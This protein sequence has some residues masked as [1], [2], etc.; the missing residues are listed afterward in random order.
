MSSLLAGNQG[1]LRRPSPLFRLCEVGHIRRF[2]A[3]QRLEDLRAGAL[4]GESGGTQSM[5]FLA[6]WFGRWRVDQQRRDW[7]ASVQ[8][9]MEDES[10][11]SR[12]QRLTTFHKQ[13]FPWLAIPGPG[14]PITVPI[15]ALLWQVQPAQ[16]HATLGILADAGLIQAQGEGYLLI[17]DFRILARHLL[18]DGFPAG[19]VF[20]SLNLSWSRA[21]AIFLQRLLSDSSPWSDH[22][23]STQL[24]W[25]LQQADQP[26][27]IQGLLD[28]YLQRDQP[29]FLEKLLGA[30]FWLD[31]A[32]GMA[33]AQAHAI[34]DAHARVYAQAQY[35]LLRSLRRLR[36]QAVPSS[37][38]RELL[39]AE[40]WTLEEAFAY[41][42]MQSDPHLRAQILQD[43][44]PVLCPEE[45]PRLLSAVEFLGADAAKAVALRGLVSHLPSKHKPRV[46]EC[47]EGMENSFYA[48]L[49]LGSF[50]PF[51]PLPLM[52]RAV[53]MLASFSDEMNQAT[54]L[55]QFLPH[56]TKP[57]RKRL[58]GLFQRFQ[59]SEAKMLVL[60][61]LLDHP[62]K[63]KSEVYELAEA[64]L[65]PLDYA[66]FQKQVQGN[67]PLEEGNLLASVEGAATEAEKAM[68]LIDA[69]S[70]CSAKQLEDLWA[71][72]QGIE[73]E[74]LR[75]NTLLHL[76]PL[77]PNFDDQQWQNLLA[78]VQ[79]RSVQLD[80]LVQWVQW[81]EQALP[82]A[83]AFVE[84][85]SDP[86]SQLDAKIQLL[87]DYPKWA[88]EVL[89]AIARQPDE[90]RQVERLV[91]T[92]PQLPDRLIA[93]ALDLALTLKSP[94]GREWV[95][96]QLT[97]RL[98]LDQML[99]TIHQLGYLTYPQAALVN[100]ACQIEKYSLEMGVDSALD[101][102][103]DSRWNEIQGL[104]PLIKGTQNWRQTLAA[105]LAMP[106]PYYRARILGRFLHELDWRLMEK[107]QW[108]EILQCLESSTPQDLINLF[109]QLALGA[110]AQVGTEILPPFKQ[111]CLSL[112]TVSEALPRVPLDRLH[113]DCKVFDPATPAEAVSDTYRFGEDIADGL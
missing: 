40:Q 10:L 110:M 88:D 105:I 70:A 18:T 5:G 33:Q 25:H 113:T 45:W 28:E 106:D 52:D 68:I 75:I 111:L 56:V 41:L 59:S 20:P 6:K 14:V 76:I 85:L 107:K 42:D 15:A 32:L 26:D 87:A 81:S 71:I 69:A 62:P 11:K 22:Y 37:W 3:A 50:A 80:I 101:D 86:L 34:S 89:E 100:L 21:H 44:G 108:S 78:S 84:Q 82:M 4:R 93:K 91:N 79:S 77:Y 96:N 46:L 112:A 60:V 19:M 94:L 97:P 90:S 9:V 99:A 103:L 31:R 73:D 74:G 53:R 58:L 67:V 64:V 48:A 63:L 109:P 51:L 35:A 24:E 55:A 30:G 49:A 1:G 57:V 92:I 95:L 39:Y 7:T 104:D 65:S 27:L 12:L 72:A 66:Q 43:L 29:D 36:M 8:R 98:D 102:I 17:H 16:A 54:V 23:L 2:Q 47:I 13:L 38:V 61:T 83:L